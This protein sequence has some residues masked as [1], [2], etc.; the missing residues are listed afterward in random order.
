MCAVNPLGGPFNRAGLNLIA[1]HPLQ[2]L[3]RDIAHGAL[4]GFRYQEIKYVTGPENVEISFVNIHNFL[5]RF[6]PNM[7]MPRVMH[8]EAVL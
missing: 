8:A 3:V 5:V 2:F 1:H 4:R 6:P 7:H